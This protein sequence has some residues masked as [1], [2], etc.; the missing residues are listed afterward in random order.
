MTYRPRLFAIQA[1]KPLAFSLV[2]PREAGQGRQLSAA[3][4]YPVELV[5]GL[6]LP[7]LP[8]FDIREM[9]KPF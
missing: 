1:I 4:A 3:L 6:V 5:N 7:W 9:M 2:D 8:S